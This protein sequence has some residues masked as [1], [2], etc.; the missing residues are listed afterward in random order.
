LLAGA[1]R[2]IDNLA[3]SHA[4][5]GSKVDVIAAADATV[6]ARASATSRQCVWLGNSPDA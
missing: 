4:A 6:L 2:G 3:M 1:E 5:R